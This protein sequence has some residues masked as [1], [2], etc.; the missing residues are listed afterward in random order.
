MNRNLKK[1]AKSMIHLQKT[2]SL[3]S[4][5]QS[6]ARMEK[7]AENLAR[8]QNVVVE[9][10][11]TSPLLFQPK[12][13]QGLITKSQ[14][15]RERRASGV[16]SSEN[17]QTAF[18]KRMAPKTWPL[19]L[20][21]RTSKS[22]RGKANIPKNEGLHVTDSTTNMLGVKLALLGWIAEGDV[23]EEVQLRIQVGSPKTYRPRY[24]HCLLLVAR[25][26]PKY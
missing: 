1:A 9:M 25:L 16:A 20:T 3:S 18:R 15:R 14:K 4:R 10:M 6:L 11:T 8:S 21:P 17:L 2:P 7:A 26:L 19:K 5:V 13:V 22:Q 24:I 23:A 12:L